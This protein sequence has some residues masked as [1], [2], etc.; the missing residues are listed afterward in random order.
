MKDTKIVDLNITCET[1]EQL[2]QWFDAVQENVEALVAAMEP[3]QRYKVK[4]A[5]DAVTITIETIPPEVE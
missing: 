1:P 5:V 4:I 3:N 2:K